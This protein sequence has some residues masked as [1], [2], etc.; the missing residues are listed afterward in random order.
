M[1]GQ[2]SAEYKAIVNIWTLI[3]SKRG[4]E[5]EKEALETLLQFCSTQGIE[6]TTDA[7][8]SV[9]IWEQVGQLIF[10]SAFRG[11]KIAISVLTIWRILMTH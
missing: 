1:G 2:I 4:I 7:A 11:D 9:K 5:H 10:D 6:V 3:L 8:F